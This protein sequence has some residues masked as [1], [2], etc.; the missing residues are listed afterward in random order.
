[1]KS[2]K[3][4]LLTLVAIAF[5][6]LIWLFNSSPVVSQPKVQLQTEPPIEQVI[7][8]ETIVKLEF[9]AL[10]TDEQPLKDANVRVRILT[11]AKNPWFTS[12][13]PIVEGTEL[14]NLD[15]IAPQGNLKFEQVFPIRGKYRIEVRVNP[16]VKG[17]FKAFEQSFTLN[18]PENAVKYRNIAILAAILLGVGF[19]SGWI[20]GGDQTVRENEIAPQPVRMLLSGITI[21][22]IAVLFLVNWSAEIAAHHSESDAVTFS[23]PSATIENEAVQVELLGDTQTVVGNLATKT[24][25]V[26]NPTTGKPRADVQVSVQSVALENNALM[27]AYQGTPDTTGKL[28]WQEQFF[29]GAPH[30]VTVKVTP[31]EN[32]SGQFTPLK[33]S[34]EIEVKAIAP[35]L[36]RRLI[37]LLYFTLIFVVGLIAGLGG[38]RRQ[39]V[40]VS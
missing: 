15:A 11:P 24:V 14:L 10:D 16:Q 34:Q 7:P 37:S 2:I 19:G 22:A 17:A 40:T 35:P 9:Q 12:D 32:S 13:F 27:F 38:R 29:D 21:V 36:L 25:Q 31:L 26:T 30:S 20:L 33:I 5:W 6:G 18:V 3:Y 28:T 23:T 1:M 4:V 39:K 8:D